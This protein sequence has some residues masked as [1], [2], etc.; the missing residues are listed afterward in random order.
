MCIAALVKDICIRLEVKVSRILYPMNIDE[1]ALCSISR[2]TD[3]LDARPGL[4]SAIGSVEQSEEE[5]SKEKTGYYVR[6]MGGNHVRDRDRWTD[7][8]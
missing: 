8:V 5:K 2:W 7:S 4:N 3:Y 6:S 1:L